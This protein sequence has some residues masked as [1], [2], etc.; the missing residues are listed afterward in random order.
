M[1]F[2]WFSTGHALT[3]LL[4]YLCQF[5]RMSLRCDLPR[6]Q[7]NLKASLLFLP[8]H[9]HFTILLQWNHRLLWPTSPHLQTVPVTPLPSLNPL[10]TTLKRRE[11]RGW[12][13][14]RNRSVIREG[15]HSMSSSSCCSLL[16]TTLVCWYSWKLFMNSWLPCP[17]HKPANQREKRRKKKRRKKTSIKR[18]QPCLV[19]EMKFR[20]LL[21]FHSSLKKPRPVQTTT[22]RCPRRKPGEY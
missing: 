3:F 1:C 5:Y 13:S 22:K 17:N 10:Q 14:S 4:S 15:D 20:I 21:L 7:M 18:K 8:R 19:L 12:Q 9:H 16:R 6:C 11:P 2:F